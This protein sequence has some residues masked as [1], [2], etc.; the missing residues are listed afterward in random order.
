MIIKSKGKHQ[1]MQEER[2]K[3][4]IKLKSNLNKTR[5]I[6]P[7]PSIKK[8]DEIPNENAFVDNI[9]NKLNSLMNL[10]KE[11]KGK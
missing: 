3:G 5:L 8:E 2:V 6:T 11:D 4:L 7:L 1:I 9:S 10:N